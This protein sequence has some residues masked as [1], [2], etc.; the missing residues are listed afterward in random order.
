MS[1]RIDAYLAKARAQKEVVNPETGEKFIIRK[2]T[3]RDY[4][5]SYQGL[6]IEDTKSVSGLYNKGKK[7]EWADLSPAEKKE[8][9]KVLDTVLIK[10]LVDPPLTRTNEEG[11]LSVD[12][13]SDSDYY[14]LIAE[15]SKYSGN[16]GEELKPFRAEPDAPAAGP[17]SETIQDA[18]ALD[19]GL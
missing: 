9:L 2:T 15:A 11:K 3:G 14:F 5:K 8:S 13:L 16:G 6:P 17:L 18:S 10:A 19:P 4:V 12:D 1:E 7:K